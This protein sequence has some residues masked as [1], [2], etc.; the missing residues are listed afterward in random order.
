VPDDLDYEWLGRFLEHPEETAGDLSTGQFTLSNQKR[1]VADTHPED[2]KGRRSLQG[3]VDAL[4]AAIA[5][6]R[7]RNT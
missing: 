4:E 5:R 6:D 3:I 1:A 7:A 2:V